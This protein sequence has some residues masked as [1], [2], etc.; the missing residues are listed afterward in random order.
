MEPS[1]PAP[2]NRPALVAGILASAAQKYPEATGNQLIQ[3]L[4]HNTGPD[5]HELSYDPENGFG[6]GIAS[7][8]HVLRE[9]P[10]QYDDENPLLDKSLDRPS[11]DEIDAAVAQFGPAEGGSN[12]PSSAPTDPESGDGV[13]VVLIAVGGVAAMVVIAAVVLTIIL[14]KRSH[15][16]DREARS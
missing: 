2:G 10:A 5:D 14:V 16:R 8:S 3:S 6:Y 9:D 11:A 1:A 7:L 12:T 15:R 4:V 13:P